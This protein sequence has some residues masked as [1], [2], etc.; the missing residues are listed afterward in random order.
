MKFYVYYRNA[1]EYIIFI[2]QTYFCKKTAENVKSTN[3]LQSPGKYIRHPSLQN[4]R[5]L[6]YR[7]RV[8]I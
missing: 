2:L 8:Q 5:N 6:P 3:R 7:P 1:R 4:P